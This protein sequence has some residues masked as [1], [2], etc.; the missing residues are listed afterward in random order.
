[1][2]VKTKRMIAE[3]IGWLAFLFLLSIV[4]GVDKGWSDIKALWWTV[5]CLL[6]WF[7]GLWKAGAF[8]RR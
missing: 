6:V 7:C 1:M 2:T 5:P 3:T 4:F 8:I